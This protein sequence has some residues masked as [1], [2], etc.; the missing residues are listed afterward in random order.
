MMYQEKAGAVRG[1]K[2][3]LSAMALM[4]EAR[5]NELRPFNA[6]TLSGFNFP[7]ISL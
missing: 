4:V 3:F 1:N 5:I 6:L 7:S 2:N